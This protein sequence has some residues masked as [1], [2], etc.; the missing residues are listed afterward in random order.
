MNRR[1]TRRLVV[2]FSLMVSALLARPAYAQFQIQG[3]GGETD[4]AGKAQFYAGA[5]GIRASFLELDVEVG[6]LDNVLPKGVL[7]ALESLEQQQGL[8][9]Q[10]AARVPATYALANVRLIAPAGPIKPFLAAGGGVARLVPQLQLSVPGISAGDVFGVTAYAVAYETMA[11]A[12]AGLRFDFGVFNVEAGYRYIVIFSQFQPTT[13]T[14]NDKV[15]TTV[16]T[17]YVALAVR[18]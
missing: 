1:R 14:N 12:E 15:L 3:L 18:F 17:V 2:A 4:A 10:V 9:I 8:P 5:V 16:N 7:N 13:N 11:D 6:H